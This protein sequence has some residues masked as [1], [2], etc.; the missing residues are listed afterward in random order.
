VD[1]FLELTWRPAQLSNTF[2]GRDVMAPAAA[3]LAAG[4]TLV[5]LT[6]PISDPVLLDLDVV[7]PGATEGVIIHIDHYGNATTNFAAD[8]LSGS[9][10]LVHAAGHRIGQLRRTY[11]D[12]PA[13]EPLALVGSGGLLEIAVRNGSAANLLGLRVGDVIELH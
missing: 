10:P 3:M 8:Q 6:R 11:A 5:R 9:P 2:H 12:V 4:P 13:G 7:Q 1:E